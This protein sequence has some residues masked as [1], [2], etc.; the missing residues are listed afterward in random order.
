MFDESQLYS[1]WLRKIREKTD[2]TSYSESAFSD[3][4]DQKLRKLVITY[5]FNFE[6]IALHLGTKVL[7]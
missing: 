4:F 2:L 1:H 6:A 5:H 3:S 7:M